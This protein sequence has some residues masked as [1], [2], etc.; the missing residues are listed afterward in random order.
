MPLDHLVIGKTAQH[1]G[2]HIQAD[3]LL[4]RL[5]QQCDGHNDL[6]RAQVVALDDQVAHFE[7]FRVCHHAGQDASIA[8]HALH[9]PAQPE[10]LVHRN[11]LSG[12]SFSSHQ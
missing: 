2:S 7:R 5:A 9:R 6:A 4:A 8:I 10:L 1:L 12:I 3:S 11:L